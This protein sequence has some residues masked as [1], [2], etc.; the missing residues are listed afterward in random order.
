[1]TSALAIVCVRNESLHIQRCLR[2]LCGDG[3]EVVLI[4]N[5]STDDT[6]DLARPFLGR[7]LR[8]IER[9]PWRGAFSLTEQLALKTSIAAGAPD[10]WIVHADADEW[11]NPPAGGGTLREA[12][13]GADAAGYTCINFHEFAFVPLP[14]E[15][16]TA[17][18]YAASMGRYYFFEPSYPRLMRAWRRDA[19][20]HY[21]NAGGHL[22]SGNPRVFPVDF[23]LRHYMMLSEAHGR[24]KY[25]GRRFAAEDLAKGWHCNRATISAENLRVGD[26]PELRRLPEPS[27]RAFDTSA[28]VRSHFWEWATNRG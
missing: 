16:F 25:L 11:L 3:I 28:P 13:A 22:L 5:D 7:G 27:S 14:G 10:D 18:E 24:V 17:Q 8:A 15:D 20:L 9:L 2:D 12:I 21:G 4:D 1:V 26:R 6:L 23:V 19:G